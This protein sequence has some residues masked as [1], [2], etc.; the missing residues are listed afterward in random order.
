MAYIHLYYIVPYILRSRIIYATNGFVLDLFYS[1][2]WWTKPSTRDVDHSTLK[3]FQV[4]QKTHNKFVVIASTARNQESVT[5]AVDIL[6]TRNSVTHSVYSVTDQKYERCFRSTMPACGRL[7]HLSRTIQLISWLTDRLTIDRHN[8]TTT[9]VIMNALCVRIHRS[10]CLHRPIGPTHGTDSLL[11]P[12]YGALQ[13][14]EPMQCDM[15]KAGISEIM[16]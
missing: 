13:K 7:R 10:V 1:V 8:Q 9:V 6:P 15:L 16:Q 12:P 11:Q 4:D 14:P 5:T 2:S 3:P